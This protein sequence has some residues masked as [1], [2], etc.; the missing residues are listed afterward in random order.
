VTDESNYREHQKNYSRRDFLTTAG[1][2]MMALPLAGTLFAQ[3]TRERPNILWIVAEDISPNLSCYGETMINTPNMD[4]L[5]SQGIRFARAYATSPVCSPCRSS[6]MTGMYQTS[7]GVHN[8]RSQS[9]FGKG[10]GNPKYYSSYHLPEPIKLLP[11][12]FQENGYT[13]VLGGPKHS[14]KGDG[15]LGKTDYNFIWETSVYD[16][17]DWEALVDNGPFFAQWQYNGGKNRDV[18]L[19]NPVDPEEVNLPPFDPD[20]PVIRESW[21]EYFNAVKDFD[22]KV[23]ELLDQLDAAGLRENTAVFLFSDHGLQHMRGKQTLY[24][25]GLQVPLIARW[26]G[27]IPAGEVRTDLVSLLDLGATSLGI[28]G[29]DIPEYFQSHNFFARNYE[30]REFIAAARDRMD[31]TV[32]ICRCIR[33]D[34][35]KYIRNFLPD[36]PHV[37]PNQYMGGKNTTLTRKQL[38][39]EGKLT[40]DQAKYFQPMRPAEELYDLENDPLELNNVAGENQYQEILADLRNKFIQWQE[41]TGDLGVIPEPE[42]E[43]MGLKYGSKYAIYQQP[44]YATLQSDLREVLQSGLPGRGEIPTLLEALESEHAPIRYWGAYC[45]AAQGNRAEEAIPALSEHLEDEDGGVRVGTA[46][47]LVLLKDDTEAKDVLLHELEANP[48][49]VVRLY[50]ALAFETW[51]KRT[52]EIVKAMDTA[53]ED[54]YEYVRRVAKRFVKES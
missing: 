37:Q 36:R 25:Q 28:A 15:N 22:N 33:T 47:T 5:A 6:L 44:E 17:S 43:D 46:R 27:K 49:H 4:R 14:S 48:N 32:D 1:V 10:A 16:S 35:Y 2:G 42:L 24:E 7:I 13:T 51:G 18:K 3:Q 29:I 31:E 38:F 53:R 9:D 54:N 19:A 30:E 11:E 26:P 34:G 20:H 45:L 40:P 21:A 41:K 12:I 39:K 50:A 8:H 52:P 23:G